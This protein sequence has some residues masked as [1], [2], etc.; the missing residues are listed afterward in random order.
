MIRFSCPGCSKVMQAGDSAAGRNAKC[1]NCGMMLAIPAAPTGDD[2]LGS[3]EGPQAAPRRSVS[4]A[5][6]PAPLSVAPSQAAPI[7]TLPGVAP[8]P[9]ISPPPVASNTAPAVK[10]P[11]PLRRPSPAAPPPVAEEPAYAAPPPAAHGGDFSLDDLLGGIDAPA[12][13]KKSS[14]SGAMRKVAAS[15]SGES[16]RSKQWSRQK[17]T[18]V[19]GGAGVAVVVLGVGGYLMARSFNQTPD[20]KV[21][22]TATAIVDEKLAPVTLDGQATRFAAGAYGAVMTRDAKEAR[23]PVRFAEAAVRQWAYASSGRG[24]DGKTVAARKRGGP[25]FVYNGASGDGTLA[26]SA[27]RATG[28]SPAAGLKSTDAAAANEVGSSES[29]ASA[30]PPIKWAAVD[31]G[32]DQ[33]YG[34][35]RVSIE[36]VTVSRLRT[37]A[38]DGLESLGDLTPNP[39]LAVWLKIKNSDAAGAVPYKSWMLAAAE[40]GHY[41]PQMADNTG[42]PVDPIR[43]E[44]DTK[45][46]GTQ[47]TGPIPAGETFH[48]KILFKPVAESVEYLQL[49]LPGEAFGQKEPLHF[50]IPR[51]M[52]KVVEDANPLL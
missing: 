9:F 2:G 26:V 36:K 13:R 49:T 3:P 22:T 30:A 29:P 45:L 28:D 40:E 15:A 50:Q 24:A 52:V 35:V 47:T 17:K 38:V 19:F 31:K 4:V 42:L 1:S 51:S 23:N 8:P 11:R 21:A 27:E 12:P 37:H 43:L 6:P 20:S 46:Q 32:E 48:D 34:E 5:A 39:V 10:P 44:K 7:A 16:S 14:K 33:G 41:V 18:T 25:L